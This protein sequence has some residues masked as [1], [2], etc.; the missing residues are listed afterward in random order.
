MANM[1]YCRFRNTQG[2]LL[3]CLN[4][5]DDRAYASDEER[6]AAFRM[7]DHFLGWCQD[8]SIIDG[9]DGEELQSTIDQLAEE[10]EY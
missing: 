9:Y 4:A 8:M 1:S 3:D 6:R 7:I 2:D 5:I 10:Y